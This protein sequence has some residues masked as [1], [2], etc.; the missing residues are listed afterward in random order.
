MTYLNEGHSDQWV[1]LAIFF[2]LFAISGLFNRPR[3]RQFE[4]VHFYIF[5]AL[6]II[7]NIIL[8]VVLRKMG[9]SD[10]S[11]VSAL[12][13]RDLSLESSFVVLG[14]CL[15]ARGFG[16]GIRNLVSPRS[17]YSSQF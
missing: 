2:G 6:T 9:M 15:I 4:S 3:A 10:Q 7:A 1:V 14:Y 12:T 5:G 8:L 17:K 11:I 13:L 16:Q